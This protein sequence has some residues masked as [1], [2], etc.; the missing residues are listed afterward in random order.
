MHNNVGD[1]GDDSVCVMKFTVPYLPYLPPEIQDRMLSPRS[2]PLL[3]SVVF[4]VR[5]I[6]ALTVGKKSDS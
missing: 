6:T 3:P 2:K 5:T 1:V 4:R